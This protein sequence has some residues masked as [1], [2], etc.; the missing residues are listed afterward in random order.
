MV[1]V[2]D[3]GP[4]TVFA[5]DSALLLSD[6]N[7]VAIG[8][9]FSREDKPRRISSTSTAPATNPIT[10]AGLL[11]SAWGGYVA[12]WFDNSGKTMGLRDP[13]GTVPCWIGRFN[14]LVVIA[15]DLETVFATGVVQPQID[16]PYLWSYLYAYDFPTHATA[17][18]NVSEL[19]PG[20]QLELGKSPAAQLPT[21]SPWDHV[22]PIPGSTEDLADRLAQTLSSTL[23]TWGSC[24]DTVVMGV[25]GGLDSSIVTEGLAQATSNLQLLTMATHDPLGDE[26]HYARILA[27]HLGLPLTEVFHETATVEIFE[28][29]STH[30]P[31]PLGRAFGQSTQRAKLELGAAISCDAY[32]SGVGGDNVFGYT[33]SA[34]PIVDRLKSE[35]LG[36]GTLQT[37]RNV[38]RLTECSVWEAVSMAGTI[39]RAPKN[40]MWLGSSDR[41]LGPARAYTPAT[42]E[43]PWISASTATLPGKFGHVAGLV[44]IQGTLG[45]FPRASCAP[46]IHPLLSQPIVELCLGI[47][48]WHWVA[49]GRN[50]GLA[51]LAYERRLPPELINRRSKGGPSGFAYDVAQVYRRQI[52]EHLLDGVGLKQGLFDHVSLEIALASDRPYLNDDH[53]RLF[54]LLEVECWAR[55]WLAKPV[56]RKMDEASGR[57]GQRAAN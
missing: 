28:P 22:A 8:H 3:R 14:G 26:R 27:A 17:L 45:S 31:R 16:W 25:S 57:E 9:V 6:G 15:S 52:R 19:M 51:R 11:S 42:T 33:Q 24:F 10:G 41:F 50:R 54:E 47:P 34:S 39:W 2:F 44:R 29:S 1:T 5:T 37:L 40:R 23:K 43:H 35:G 48:S 21:W 4:L 30:L 55:Y 53:V 49:G 18:E 38:C 56:A 13:S 32:F 20:F 7:G 46:Q 36:K 12:F